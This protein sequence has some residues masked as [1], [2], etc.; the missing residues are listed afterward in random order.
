MA[1]LE[2][3]APN[4]RA[5]LAPHVPL[6]FVDGHRLRP[7]HD[8]QRHSLMRIAAEAADLKIEIS[9]VQ[10]VAEARRG[11]SRSFETQ[12]ALVPGD[13]R[14]TVSFLPPRPRAPPN[15]EPNY[16]KCFRE[17]WCSS[18]DNA[19]A[20]LRSASRYG[21]GSEETVPLP[22][23]DVDKSVEIDAPMSPSGRGAV[24]ARGA[25]PAGLPCR[26]RKSLHGPKQ[27][28]TEAPWRSSTQPR[29]TLHRRRFGSPGS[30]RISS[31]RSC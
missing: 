3:I 7:A 20:W 6:Q 26:Y 11:L 25:T 12:H 24:G 23:V 14:Q 15:A 19:P 31:Q 30:G 5:V 29:D 21:L 18:T 28:L 27:R 9:C 10:S 17:I 4:L 8:V 13:T 1:P 2:R 16:R 22:I